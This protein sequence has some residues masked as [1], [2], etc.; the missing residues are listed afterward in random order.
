[1]H[2]RTSGFDTDAPP[3]IMLHASPASSRTLEPLA[4]EIA[5]NR[6]VFLPDTPGNGA[7]CAPSEPE[8]DLAV[9]A[10]MMDRFCDGLGL[11]EVDVY[12]THT[13]AHIAIEWAINHPGRIR[14]LIL[15]GVALLSA[16]DRAE[17][18][19]NYAPPCV[20]DAAGTQFAWAWN[21]IRDQMI[22][23]PHYRQD[24]AHMRSGGKFEPRLLHDLTL[25]LLGALETYH[26][27]YRA[28]F[29]HEPLLR[30]PRVTIP[31]LWL[32]GGDS[33]L[34]ANAEEAIA[35]L[36][37]ALVATVSDGQTCAAA[38]TGFLNARPTN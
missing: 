12:G 24:A 27:A 18:L 8:P 7:S 17:F 33:P 4:L 3:L 2:Y 21:L 32:Q 14:S 11:A 20:P 38:I 26:Q 10:G 22:F 19:E 25:D 35:A 37:Q 1:M 23:W 30:L 5:T 16:S 34:D 9:Y 36:P 6:R 29:Q 13:G 31:T 28:V 15:D